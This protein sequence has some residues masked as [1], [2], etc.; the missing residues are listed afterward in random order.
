MVPPFRRIVLATSRWK[1]V[2]GVG[3]SQASKAGLLSEFDAR[4]EGR[5][6]TR[7]QILAFA[8]R[9][10]QRLRDVSGANLIGP[11]DRLDRPLGDV[12]VAYFKSARLRPSL[13]GGG[14]E[15]TG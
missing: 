7:V 5:G 2:I 8:V 6:E 15:V 13:A 12:T 14:S 1:A 4:P 10:V 11:A 3:A 9:L